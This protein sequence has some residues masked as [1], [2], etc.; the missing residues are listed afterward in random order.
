MPWTGMLKLSGKFVT[1]RPDLFFNRKI[2]TQRTGRGLKVPLAAFKAMKDRFGCTVNDAVLAVASEGLPLWFK[3]RRESLPA[4]V[5]VFCS[6]SVRSDHTRGRLLH[7]ISA[8]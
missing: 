4:R 3:G 6:G 1:R 8:L 7:Q 2:G 5:G